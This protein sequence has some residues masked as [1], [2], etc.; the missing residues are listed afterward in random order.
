MSLS[1][2]GILYCFVYC[3]G[4]YIVRRHLRL[5][6]LVR[7]VH[8]RGADSAPQRALRK[9]QHPKKIIIVLTCA[10]SPL[11]CPW[12]VWQACERAPLPTNQT[13][14]RLLLLRLWHPRCKVGRQHILRLQC[15]CHSYNWS[16]PW[17]GFRSEYFVL[18]LL[19]AGPT[20]LRCVLSWA[21]TWSRRLRKLNLDL[22]LAIDMFWA[23]A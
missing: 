8:C 5:H 23:I 6:G 17:E 10:S 16:L 12:Q 4:E 19:L 1:M 9:V 7:P 21:L 20:M 18:I 15:H 11:R 13:A 22:N 2:L 14:R 3:P